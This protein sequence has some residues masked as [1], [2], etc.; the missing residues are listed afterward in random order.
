[1]IITLEIIK[2][3]PYFAQAVPLFKILFFKKIVVFSFFR[4]EKLL[5]FEHYIVVVS[6]VLS[7][8]KAHI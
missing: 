6:A 2:S 8:Q 4:I 7:R 5:L 1:M 3:Y